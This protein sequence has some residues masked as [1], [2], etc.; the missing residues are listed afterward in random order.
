MLAGCGG[1]DN[2]KPNP[3][4]GTIAD[5]LAY[6]G[7]RQSEF[8][9]RATAGLTPVLVEK[10]PGGV[11][12]TARRVAHWRPLIERAAANGPVDADT[13]E[14]IVLLESAGRPDAR[15]RTTS[16]ARSA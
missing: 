13:L 8:E 12:A 10:S 14:A 11:V 7:T 3:D 16:R 5:P 15:A 9:A 6:D 2:P 1:S 4:A